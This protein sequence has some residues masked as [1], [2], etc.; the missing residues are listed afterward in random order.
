MNSVLFNHFSAPQARK[1]WGFRL[2]LPNFTFRNWH[3]AVNFWKFSYI[4]VF[5]LKPVYTTDL[6]KI[7]CNVIYST[8]RQEKDQR[9]PHPDR[10]SHFENASGIRKS[11]FWDP[12]KWYYQSAFIFLNFCSRKINLD[13][14]RERGA[15]FMTKLH[16][17][18][19][20][21]CLPFVKLRNLQVCFINCCVPAL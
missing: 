21:I 6:W 20:R 17:S 7:S 9:P 18:R 15:H 16:N 12:L 14:P 10:K 3:F 5:D 4:Y 1:F 2:L 8:F 13:T 11:I 19:I